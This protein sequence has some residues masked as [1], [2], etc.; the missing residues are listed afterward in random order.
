MTGC[1]TVI[2]GTVQKIQLTLHRK[3]SGGAMKKKNQDFLFFLRHSNQ[4]DE[5]LFIAHVCINWVSFPQ[6]EA[7]NIPF[8]PCKKAKSSIR[9]AQ[10][11]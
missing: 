3:T 6:T 7:V 5:G 9:K 11:R 8:C 2:S 1:G 10:V 4:T